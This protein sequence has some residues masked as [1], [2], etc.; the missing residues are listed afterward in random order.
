M[1]LAACLA[2]CATAGCAVVGAAYTA[3]GFV[4]STTMD[5]AIGVG[6]V[7]TGVASGVANAGARALTPAPTAEPTVATAAGASAVPAPALKK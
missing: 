6:R 5:A 3:T 2:L 1:M 4:V 7:A